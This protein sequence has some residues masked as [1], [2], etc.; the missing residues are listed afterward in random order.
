M[1]TKYESIW[2]DG[3]VDLCDLCGCAMIER[4][5]YIRTSTTHSSYGM[6]ICESCLARLVSDFREGLRDELIR[7]GMSAGAAGRA[8]AGWGR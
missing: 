8:A 1:R 2:D 3:D 4:T 6:D 5:L 7:G